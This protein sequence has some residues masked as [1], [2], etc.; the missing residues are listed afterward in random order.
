[1]KIKTLVAMLFLSAGATTV[2]AQDATN[3]NSNSSISHEA[4][5]AGNFKDAYTPWKAVLENCPTLRFYTFTDG[6]KI[7]KGLMAQINDKN[8]PEYQKYF[9]ELMKTHDLRMQYTDDFIAKG[10]KVSS[11][12]E[13]LGIKAVD[14]IALAP[15]VDPSLAYEWLSKSVN[16][17]KGESAAATLFYFLQMSLDKLKTDPAHKEQFIQDYLVA[18]EYADA[19]IAMETNEAKKNNFMGIKDNLV[20]LFV[21][22]GTADCESL[23]SIY[24]PKVEANQSDLDYLKKVIDIMKM[25]KCT[26]SEAYLQASFYV[27]KIEPTADAAAGC[28]YQAYKKGDIDGAVK[29]FDEAIQLE[30]DNVKKAELAYAAG[31][32]LY[33]AKKLAQSRSYCQKAIGFNENY[34]APYILIATLYATSPNWSDEP[35]LNKCTYFAIIDKLQRAKSV[36]PSVAEEA[37]RLIGTYSGHTPQAKDLFMLGYKQGDRITIGG[38]IGETTTIR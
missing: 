36:D 22:S 15:K 17:V 12:D 38:W 27:Y 6:Y 18:T 3:C 23:Q 14:Y 13:A 26:E 2:V 8:N 20:A 21:N 1:M 33:S 29:F 11:A 9:D 5:R 25:M 31:A 32:V 7:L 10:T 30:Q 37:N 34:G 35:A 19:A 28:A 24:G 16:A 4:V